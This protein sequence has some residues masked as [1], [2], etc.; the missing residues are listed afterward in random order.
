MYFTR[1]L[2]RGYNSYID[3]AADDM[4]TQMD[5][6]LLIMEPGDTFTVREPEKVF[7]SSFAAVPTGR[8]SAA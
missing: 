2:S 8:S 3:S 7:R 5:V 1:Q 6:G 4:G